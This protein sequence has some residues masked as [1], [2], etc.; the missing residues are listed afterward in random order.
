MVV[1]RQLNEQGQKRTDF[2]REEFLAKIWAWKE[3]SGGTIVSQ[4]KR[5]GAS[6]DW[7]RTAFTM[8]GAQGDTRV[9][10]KKTSTQAGFL[11]DCGALLTAKS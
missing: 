11:F 7:D 5:L 10:H 6:C 4:L 9:G 8:A 2:T 1:E 3:Q